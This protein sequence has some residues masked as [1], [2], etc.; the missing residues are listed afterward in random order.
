[1]V[2][3]KK[4]MLD[5]EFE[6]AID[7][8]AGSMKL[9]FSIPGYTFEDI[10]QEIALK[11]VECSSKFN[12]DNETKASFVTFLFRVSYNHLY[13]IR[14]SVMFKPLSPC[15]KCPLHVSV[16]KR[17]ISKNIYAYCVHRKKYEFQLRDSVYLS[18]VTDDLIHNCFVLDV[19]TD[20][21]VEDVSKFIEDLPPEVAHSGIRALLDGEIVSSGVF[22]S[23]KSGMSI[24]INKY[25]L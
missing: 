9:K 7:E 25:G 23:I 15:L 20:E 8:V 13:N 2:K 17:C 6:N 22:E 3:K 10:K 24:Y 18:K 14:H 16:R 11:A 12:D 5:K 19:N 21:L 1:M 4:K